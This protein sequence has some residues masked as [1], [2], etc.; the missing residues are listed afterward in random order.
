M[1]R[2]RLL[3]LGQVWYDREIGDSQV[4]AIQVELNDEIA[5]ELSLL[6][7]A[8]KRSETEIVREA[9]TTYVRTVRP[10]PTGIGKYRSGDGHVSEQAR[11]I[12]RQATKD[13]QWP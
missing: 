9:L 13:R 2:T 7:A 3:P 5:K 8:Q 10:M 1:N 6:A 12:L 4:T 11:D